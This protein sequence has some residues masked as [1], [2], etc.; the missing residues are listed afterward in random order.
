M[1]A[2]L[3]LVMFST[4]EDSHRFEHFPQS[5]KTDTLRPPAAFRKRRCLFTAARRTRNKRVCECV[6]WSAE[7]MGNY[8][9]EHDILLCSQEKKTEICFLALKGLF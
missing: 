3:L 8:Q 6:G 1:K 7:I 9:T 4:L 5:R 2:N